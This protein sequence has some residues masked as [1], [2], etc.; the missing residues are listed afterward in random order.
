V[1]RLRRTAR[2]REARRR[3]PEKDRRASIVS[4]TKNG[5]ALES[6]VDVVWREL[7]RATVVGLDDE[8]WALLLRTTLHA[9]QRYVNR[10]TTEFS[11]T[12]FV[13]SAS[14]GSSGPKAGPT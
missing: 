5:K 8:Q 4:P 7:E 10:T 6:K 9:V 11:F 13:P 2:A 3:T 1:R 12:S 14:R